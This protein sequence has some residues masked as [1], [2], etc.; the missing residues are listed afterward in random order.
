[1]E[2]RV[3]M[4][5]V[6]LEYGVGIGLTCFPKLDSNLRRFDYETWA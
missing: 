2:Y 1:M 3:G 6:E 5:N 4:W